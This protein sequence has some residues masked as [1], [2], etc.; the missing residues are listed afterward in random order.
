MQRSTFIIII[1]IA[2]VLILGTGFVAYR[3]FFTIPTKTATST[4]QGGN[5]FGESNTIP[6]KY[7]DTGNKEVGE[8]ASTDTKNQT[9]TGTDILIRKI[10][11]TP[12]AGIG[13]RYDQYLVSSTSTKPT[14]A[15]T[16][17]I[18]YTEKDSGHVV[19]F[20]PKNDTLSTLSTTRLPQTYESSFVN[21][22]VQAVLRRINSDT[23]Q[24]QTVV[25]QL[26]KTGDLGTESISS[27]LPESIIGTASKNNLLFYIVKT[28]TGS[29]GFIYDLKTKKTTK[30]LESPLASWTPTWDSKFIHLTTKSANSEAGYSYTLD[31]TK[32][33]LSKTFGPNN[34]LGVLFSPSG[35]LSLVTQMDGSNIGTSIVDVASQTN[36]TDS[37][38]TIAGD[39]CAWSQL[40]NVAIC[41]VFDSSNGTYPDDWYKGKVN[42]QDTFYILKP[43]DKAPAQIAN[44]L[45]KGLDVTNI[46]IS[47]DGEYL[48]F[49]NKKDSSPWYM[50]VG[51]IL[52]GYTSE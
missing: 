27:V 37:I 2:S 32:N 39:K 41:A 38:T 15:T 16:T 30:V 35:A 47:S 45:D 25:L 4:Q 34:G 9:V 44:T 23:N 42:T 3:T 21:N 12:S 29:S 7:T 20:N 26:P 40:F 49:I 50:E 19:Q 31:L 46:S 1:S 5:P 51:D 33:L 28:N 11:N 24:I 52:R 48:V 43:Y 8:S 18:L 13:F 6:G 10:S 17:T 14:Y 22:G 36:K